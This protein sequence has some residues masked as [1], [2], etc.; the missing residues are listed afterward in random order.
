MLAALLGQKIGMTQVYDD[1]GR[2]H[3]VTV[4][5]AGPCTVL[6]IKSVQSD[7]Y[8][9]VQIGFEDLKARRATRPQIGHAAKAGARPKKHVR[10]VRLDA[11]A[12]EVQPGQTLRARAY[13]KNWTPSPIAEATYGVLPPELTFE[14]PAVDEEAAPDESTDTPADGE[15]EESAEESAD[16]STPAE[17]VE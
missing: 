6:Q 1:Q 16:E 17:P 13:R 2:A 3:P 8:D 10:E 7:G 11:P 14:V 9:A 5:R 4:V 12:D 15:G